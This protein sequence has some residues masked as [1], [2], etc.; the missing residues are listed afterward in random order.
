MASFSISEN[1]RH[2]ISIVN[3]QSAMERLDP[4]F[5]KNEY[6][7]L[8]KSF[9][10]K[11]FKP[12][13]DIIN[14]WDRGDGPRDG[15]YTDNK[16]E[17]FFLRVQNLKENS[18]DLTDVKFIYR[19]IHN[20]KLLRSQVKPGDI[21]LAIS[22]TKNNLGTISII[23]NNIKEA[24][25]N[26]ALVKLSIDK[27]INKDFFCLLFDL[28]FVRTQ[29]DFI[30]KGA[31]Q[32]N[33]NYQEFSSIKVPDIS[34]QK[35]NEIV[36]MYQLAKEKAKQSCQ[37]AQ[38]LLNSINDYLLNELQIELPQTDNSLENRM[39]TV[40]LS[41]ISGE[42]FD[43]QSQFNKHYRIQ[44]GKYKNESL[45][46]LA[47]LQK[48]QSIT[49]DEVI[50]GDYPVIAGGQSSPYNHHIANHNGN[51]IT[52]SASGSAGYVWYHDYPIFASDCTVIFSRNEDNI[53]TEF[54]AEILKLKQQ[55]IYSLA[56]G[57]VQTHVYA[58]D[59]A[60][61]QIPVPPQAIQQKIIA[62]IRQICQQASNLYQQADE[63]LFQTKVEIEQMIL[64]VS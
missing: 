58:K 45:K 44:G 57:G 13:S 14:S 31:A 30:G 49:S 33:I 10:D 11:G 22:G 52:V 3:S 47:I 59:L 12:L 23:P 4:F 48:G 5:H 35:Q 27:N 61:L 55:E 21:V 24:N 43:A 42:Q 51:V 20:T 17:I 38:T 63:Q 7:E 56:K 46:K 8:R 50:D 32:N 1:A 28:D 15:F 6:I 60:L 40:K 36:H 29:I 64:G 9:T 26:S 41:E 62:H 2:L 16:N 19:H 25:L 37:Q 53:S 34:S 18:I 54:L 39:F